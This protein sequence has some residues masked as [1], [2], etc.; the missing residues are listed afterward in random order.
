[1]A[2]IFGS[3]ENLIHDTADAL[4]QNQITTKMSD[5]YTGFISA[6]FGILDDSLK[7]VRDITTTP[8][9]PPPGP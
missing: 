6:G 4:I 9:P 5:M 3:I 1:M 7:V 2:T 8:P